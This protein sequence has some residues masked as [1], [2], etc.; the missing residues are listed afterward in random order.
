M[1]QTDKLIQLNKGISFRFFQIVSLR[2]FMSKNI[3]LGSDR[4]LWRPARQS[5]QQKTQTTRVLRSVFSL[6]YYLHNNNNKMSSSSLSSITSAPVEI[7]IESPRVYENDNSNGDALWLAW[8][9][10]TVSTIDGKK[11]ILQDICG[12][13]KGQFMAIMGPSGSGM[14]T[15]YVHCFETIHKETIFL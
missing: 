3:N 11:I 4:L 2:A 5:Q 8:K 9:N 1:F 6:Y 12:G 15:L 10:L 14:F 13:V 7:D